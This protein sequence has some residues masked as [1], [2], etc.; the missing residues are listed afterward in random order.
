MPTTYEPIATTTLG[1]AASSITFSSITSA[2]TDLRLVVVARGGSGTGTD[3]ELNL[4]FN[5]DTGSN[6]SWTQLYGTG[7]AAAST[8]ASSQTYAY[9][10]PITGP[11]AT[12][13][14]WSLSTIDIF[15]YAGSTFK[16][17]LTTSSNDQNGSGLVNRSVPLWRSTSAIT[18]IAMTTNTT[19]AAGTTATLYGIKNA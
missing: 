12:A 3:F 4:N 16:T 15:S 10:G 1:T 7:S 8:R 2:Y 5:S 19:F 14:I 18:S 17:L 9:C 13:G 6:Y 11:T